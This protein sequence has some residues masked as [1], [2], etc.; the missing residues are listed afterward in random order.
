M[1]PERA[2]ARTTYP[3][4]D[5]LKPGL[6]YEDAGARRAAAKRTPN[7]YEEA[8]LRIECDTQPGRLCCGDSSCGATGQLLDSGGRCGKND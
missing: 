8:G 6:Q 4:P 1:K 7:T 5:R 3:E 2:K